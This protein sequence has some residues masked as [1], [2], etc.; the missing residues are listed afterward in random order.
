MVAFMLLSYGATAGQA[1]RGRPGGLSDGGRHTKGQGPNV[2]I[3]AAVGIPFSTS[4][5]STS[6][7]RVKVISKIDVFMLLS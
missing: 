2:N 4:V 6:G 3:R 1:A 7:G 5:I